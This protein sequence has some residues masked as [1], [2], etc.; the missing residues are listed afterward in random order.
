[1]RNVMAFLALAWAI[2]LS[3]AALS[4]PP[5][6]V[7]DSSVLILLAQIIIFITTLVGVTL[8]NIFNKLANGNPDQKKMAKS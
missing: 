4:I 5:A 2:G 6:G 1:M 7:I 8:P 3:V